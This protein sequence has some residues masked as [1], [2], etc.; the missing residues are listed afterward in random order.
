MVDLSNPPELRAPESITWTQRLP[1]AGAV[2]RERWLVE[3]AAGQRVVHIG[4]VDELF[5]GQKT[6]S[7]IWLHGLLDDVSDSLVGLDVMPDGVEW[8]RERG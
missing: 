6:V 4:F 3:L 8:A 1:R 7:G 5:I 2:N